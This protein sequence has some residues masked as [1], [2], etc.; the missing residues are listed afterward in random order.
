[1]KSEAEIREMIRT[2]RKEIKEASRD[3]RWDYAQESEC[4]IVALLWVLGEMDFI[5]LDYEPMRA[6]E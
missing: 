1:M 2:L 6:R 3:T 4:K 5:S